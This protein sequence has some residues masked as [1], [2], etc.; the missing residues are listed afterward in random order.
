MT[1]APN[2]VFARALIS[3]LAANGV[4]RYVL[5][6]GS[7]SGP[8]AHALAEAAYPDP[9]HGAPEVELHVRID[10]RSA[11]FVA[12]GL[13]LATGEPVGIVTTSGTA[14]G[15]LLPSIMEAYHAGVPLV[16]IT[17]DRPF[18][19]RGTGA[20]QTTDQRGIFGR[21]VQWSRDVFPRP[22]V[23]SLLPRPQL[24]RERP[25]LTRWGPCPHRV[26]LTIRSGPFTSISS[27]TLL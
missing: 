8:L 11:G 2:A 7:R 21:F 25:W 4:H 13:A 27:S 26:P 23:G 19:V 20:N 22:R 1:A 14:V 15:N 3:H 5:C 24:S 10:E 9:P 17:A 16:V 6:P 12:L 18:D